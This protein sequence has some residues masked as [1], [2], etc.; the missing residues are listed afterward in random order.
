MPPAPTA[1]DSHA[2]KGLLRLTMACNERCPFC[3]VPAEDYPRPTPPAEEVE[4]QLQAFLATGQQTLT[5]SGGEPTLLRKRLVALVARARALGIPF[6]ELQTNAV[7]LDPAYADELAAAGLTSAF[8]S[9]LSHEPA[10]HDHLAGLAGAW[11]RC[12]AGI[13]ALL[14]AGVRVTL[15]PV[16]ARASQDTVPAYIDFVAARLPGVRSISLS[17]VQPHGRARAHLD[18]LL[19]DY[20]ILGEAV[21]VARARAEAH[22]IELLNPY[23][24]LPACVG[25]EAGLDHS[26]EAIEAARGGW[27]DRPGIENTGD[28]Q[29]GAPCRDCALRPRCGGAW[30]AVWEQRG[31]AGIAPPV[32]LRPPWQAGAE[33]APGQ[34]LARDLAGLAAVSEAAWTV[35]VLLDGLALDQVGPL[36]RSRATELALDLPAA[37]L[38][39]AGPLDRELV[40]A[41]R[42]L[43]R[44]N[45]LR[46][47]QGRLRAWLRLR[48]DDVDQADRALQ[49]ARNL[50]VHAVHVAGAAGVHAALLA[51]RA[52]DLL[53]EGGSP[54]LAG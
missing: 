29:H 21:R 42:R 8:I 24:G 26:V 54:V 22:G 53:V 16:F 10:L 7:L 33:H 28:K 17:A 51:R 14:A 15:N 31:G 13:D 34:A 48:T 1:E 35:W 5:I 9:L 46:Q 52:P 47:P 41:L 44:S 25:W 39:P 20:A 32:R 6:V 38:D 23:C 12:L 43:D 49:L 27:Q 3:N 36:L 45:A 18:A 40:R 37:A 4:A 2:T 30:H 19:P 11:P 50:G